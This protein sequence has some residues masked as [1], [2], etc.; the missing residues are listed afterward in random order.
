[1]VGWEERPSQMPIRRVS[2][3]T[4]SADVFGQAR[5]LAKMFRTRLYARV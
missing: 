2:Q 5:S 3:K 4:E 1:M